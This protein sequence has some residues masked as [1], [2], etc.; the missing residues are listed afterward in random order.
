MTS[1]KDPLYALAALVALI[2]L[3]GMLG[4]KST[5]HISISTHDVR[6]LLSFRESYGLADAI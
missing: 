4:I 5:I 1:K 2:N 6:R 3:L